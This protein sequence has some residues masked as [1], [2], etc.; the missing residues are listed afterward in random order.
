MYKKFFR[1]NDAPFQLTPNHHYFYGSAVHRRA[2]GYLTFGL[3]QGEG[4]VV[5]TGEVGAGKTT[6]AA[7]LLAR[8]DPV[9]FATATVVTTQLN[10]TD[11]LRMV[12]ANFD[13]PYEGLDKA[14]IL[15][16]LHRHLRNISALGGRAVVVVDEVQ[17]LSMSALEELRMLS[18]LEVGSPPA[19]QVLLVGQPQFRAK[20]MSPDLAQLRQRIVATYHLGPITADETGAYI[21]HRLLRAGWKNDPAI[22]ED[23]YIAV[24]TATGGVPR[25]IN[26]L[27]TRVLLFAYLEQLH[28]VDAKLVQQV[29]EEMRAEFET[30]TVAAPPAVIHASGRRA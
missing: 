12:A 29:A 14:T 27:F 20:M 8:L 25:I 4:F 24:Y 2:M 5:I 17:N 28:R 13:L 22:D 30:P 11:I 1:L 21:R 19:L 26:Q 3:A 18:N 9:K 6:L 10:G 7:H 23:A 16:R 15:G